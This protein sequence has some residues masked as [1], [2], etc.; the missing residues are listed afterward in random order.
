MRIEDHALGVYGLEYWGEK[1]DVEELKDFR[2]INLVGGLYKLLAKVLANRLKLAVGEVVSKNQHAF[3]Q[4]R[5]IL[6][7]VLIASEAIDSRRGGSIEGFKVGRSSREGRDLLH[8]LLADD[9]PIFL[10]RDK[11]EVI[12]VGRIESLEDVASVMGFRVGKL[13][14]SYLGLPLSASFKSSRNVCARCEKIQKDFLWGSGALEKKP[15]LVNWSLVYANKEGD[16]RIRS[17]VALNKAFLG[18]WSWRFAE[19]R[20]S[21]GNKSS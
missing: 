13:P 10:N 12:P 8:F 9:T 2:L 20:E 11:S 19:E 21:F 18:K 4:G 17:L 1:G 14:T 3:I 15:H 6:D 7:T 16:L 5:Q